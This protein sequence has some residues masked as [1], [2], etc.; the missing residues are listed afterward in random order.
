MFCKYKDLKGIFK[1]S[2]A[3]NCVMQQVRTEYNLWPLAK[4]FPFLFMPDFSFFWAEKSKEELPY[5]SD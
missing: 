1:V 5:Y 4:M 2:M 3:R